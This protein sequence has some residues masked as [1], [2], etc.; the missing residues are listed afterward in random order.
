MIGSPTARLRASVFCLSLGAQST[1]CAEYC[2]GRTP[3]NAHHQYIKVVEAWGW[4]YREVHK[5][6]LLY[7]I[8]NK[9]NR[10]TNFSNFIFVKKLYMFRAV[11]QPIIRSFPLYIRHWCMSCKFDDIY[12]C[13]TYS[14]KLLM[15]GRG[16]ARNM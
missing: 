11:P 8:F 14:G 12:Q 7:F 15:M 1:L 3:S 16:T 9:T 10:C 4:P 13:R 2:L 5:R 6:G